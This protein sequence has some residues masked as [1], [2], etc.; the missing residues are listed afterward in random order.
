MSGFGGISHANKKQFIDLI[1]VTSA[2]HTISFSYTSA[3]GSGTLTVSSGGAVVASIELIGSYTQSDFRIGSGVSGTVAITDPGVVN[4]GSVDPGAIPSFAPHH[5]IDL[6]EIGFGAQA[7]LAYAEIS[8]D[9]A[10][11]AAANGGNAASIALLGHHIAASFV[12][13]ADG[14]G[15]TPVK[16]AQTEQPLLL[17]HPPHG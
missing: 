7:T 8:A 12:A 16:E 11:T 10:G 4:G 13:A 2:A 17:T 9:A 6:P 15:G 5:G 1:S 14:L 3:A